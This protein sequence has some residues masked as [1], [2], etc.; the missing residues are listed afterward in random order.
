MQAGATEK[1][2]HRLSGYIMIN[3]TTPGWKT[4]FKIGET[5]RF[6][7]GGLLWE[8]ASL[9]DL[10]EAAGTIAGSSGDKENGF[11]IT[12]GA[13]VITVASASLIAAVIGS[14]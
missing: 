12:E 2:Y 3:D 6:K 11:K 7:A 8:D 13:F 1:G 10:K 14:F 9:I 4:N 5:I